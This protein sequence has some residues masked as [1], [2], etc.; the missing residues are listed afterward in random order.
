MLPTILYAIFRPTRNRHYI[1]KDRHKR[2]FFISYLPLLVLVSL[3]V[4]FTSRNHWWLVLAVITFVL[5]DYFVIDRFGDWA[6]WKVFKKYY[7]T[8][9]LSKSDTDLFTLMKSYEANPT[10]AKKEKI[11]KLLNKK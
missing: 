6:S 5:F 7:D 3:F 4:I 2:W 8:P 9:K 1:G 11:A 10:T